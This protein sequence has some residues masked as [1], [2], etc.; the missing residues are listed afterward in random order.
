M[1]TVIACWK[2]RLCRFLFL[3]YVYSGARTIFNRVRSWG[4]DDPRMLEIDRVRIPVADT[5]GVIR[6]HSRGFPKG[7]QRASAAG[8]MSIYLESPGIPKPL[9]RLALLTSH[10]GCGHIEIAFFECGDQVVLYAIRNMLAA[11][12]KRFRMASWFDHLKLNQGEDD[13]AVLREV[14]ELLEKKRID[15]SFASP[16]DCVKFSVLPFLIA[17]HRLEKTKEAIRR[18]YKRTIRLSGHKGETSSNTSR[19][20]TRS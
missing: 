14:I 6:I 1:K 12:I 17:P 4:F 10:F 15:H 8:M 5:F 7:L 18:N 13:A 2:N 3:F 19:Q 20:F 9:Y 11:N 16:D